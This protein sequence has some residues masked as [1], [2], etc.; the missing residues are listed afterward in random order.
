MTE[1]ISTTYNLHFKYGCVSAEIYLLSKLL[2]V[3][4][5]SVFLENYSTVEM[6]RLYCIVLGEQEPISKHWL[7]CFKPSAHTLHALR[8]ILWLM[9]INKFS[10][11]DKLTRVQYV[12]LEL[13]G[14]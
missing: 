11:T 8:S 12:H 4:W 5:Y 13:W 14:S 7:L 6:E 2:Y 9:E 10:Y 3:N 1:I